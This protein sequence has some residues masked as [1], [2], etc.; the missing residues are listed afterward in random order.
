MKKEQIDLQ[1]IDIP[2]LLKI[3]DQYLLPI[4]AEAG[5]MLTDLYWIKSGLTRLMAKDGELN[6]NTL[7]TLNAVDDLYNFL[8]ELNRLMPGKK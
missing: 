8:E 7:R 6:K 2:K 3:I 1:K 5:T 4:T